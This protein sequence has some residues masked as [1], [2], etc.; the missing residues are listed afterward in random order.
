MLYE[1]LS[2]KQLDD[3][4]FR[5]IFSDDYFDLYVWFSD[6][7]IIGFQLS[8][9][10]RNLD[11]HAL[12]WHNNNYKH[13]KVRKYFSGLLFKDGLLDKLELIKRFEKESVNL[14]NKIKS[15]VLSK[16]SEYK[17]LEHI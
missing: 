15:F 3:E 10:V 16:I 1:L 11:E 12:I 5:R 9:N 14:D 13:L 8:Y 2:V 4:P 7:E 6:D 17:D